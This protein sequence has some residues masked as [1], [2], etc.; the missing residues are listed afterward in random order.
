MNLTAVEAFIG[1]D[2]VYKT[3]DCYA[4]VCK[5]SL[6]IFGRTLPGHYAIPAL[7]NPAVNATLFS[8]ASTSSDWRQIGIPADGCVVL[9]YSRAGRP[10]H[11]GLHVT[12]GNVLHC[13]G[14]VRRPGTT[15]YERLAELSKIYRDLRFYEQRPGNDSTR[16]V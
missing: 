10:V 3:H 5:A 11:V 12:G 13:P 2:W 6:A 15:R 4:V 16:P 8:D 9:F 7:S 1:T 14:S